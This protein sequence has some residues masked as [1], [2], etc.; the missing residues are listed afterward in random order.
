MATASS[1]LN[2]GDVLGGFRVDQLIGIGGTAI[3]YR[4][5]QISLG[6]PVALKVLADQL[7]TD[8]VFRE[9]FRREGKHLA[10]FEHPN[11]V[12]VHDSGE[13]DGLLYLAMRLVEGTNLA[14]LIRG[15]GLTA[16]HTIEILGPI[17]SA[18]DAAHADGLVHRDV[19]PQNILITER[20]HP[21]L[22]DF[23]VAKGSN[24]YGLTATGGFV[25]SVNY[26]SPEQIRGS[27]LTPASDIY[28]LTAV[29]Y[30][31]LT[32]DVPYVRE[33]DAAIMHAHLHEPP[34]AL[35]A[36][37]DDGDDLDAAIAR[38]MAKEPDGR[39]GH[40]RE[41]LEAA[42][43]AV[44]HMPQARRRAV[45]AFHHGEDRHMDLAKPASS[46]VDASPSP[47]QE[48]TAADRRRAACLAPAPQATTPSRHWPLPTAIAGGLL[49]AVAAVGSIVLSGGGSKRTAV[50]R[51]ALDL[52]AS[53]TPA[54]SPRLSL[55]GRRSH[56]MR[57][58]SEAEARL[59]AGDAQAVAA[60]SRPPLGSLSRQRS[61]A[62][63][64]AS[65]RQEASAMHTLATAAGRGDRSAYTRSLAPIPAVQTGL[66]E[67]LQGARALGFSAPALRAISTHTLALPAPPRRTPHHTARS[68]PAST[69]SAVSSTAPT[70][71]PTATP[72]IHESAA[73]P[74]VSRPAHSHPSRQYG[75]TVVSPPAE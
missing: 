65:L 15:P 26:A 1:I 28:A 29:L 32:G 66:T 68:T 5:E 27:T 16:D 71:A 59:A 64:V 4:A 21:Y 42:T 2:P 67:S 74:A 17:A 51:E 44:N 14:E 24:T 61:I 47:A 72:P 46:G 57:S 45:P 73:P 11:I 69:P 6:R 8:D 18:L 62:I 70:T 33:A 9:R 58:L 48:P 13:Q 35:P 25:G 43:R 10:A 23:G 22:A 52:T 31:C 19:K 12:P 36:S 20:G 54:I 30:H 3:V 41:L 60:L 38:G 34:P 53:L 63:L 75:P 37:G 7:A 56:S 39:Y 50:H 40:A 55:A 49:V